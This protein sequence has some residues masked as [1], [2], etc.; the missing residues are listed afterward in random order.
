MGST[1]RFSADLKAEAD[2]YAASLG[3]SFNALCAV[4]VRDYLDARKAPA[5]SE[6][7]DRSSATRPAL[8]AADVRSA[9]AEKA[10][11]RS[12]EARSGRSAAVPDISPAEG[13]ARA[14]AAMAEGMARAWHRSGSKAGDPYKPCPCG[15]GDK[16]KFCRYR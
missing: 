11:P 8:V 12:P 10:P 2:A 16:A 3:I 1:L 6:A 13:K 5:L 9:A 14:D 15:S 4:A 7:G